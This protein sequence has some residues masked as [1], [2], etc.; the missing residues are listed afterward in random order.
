MQRFGHLRMGLTA[1]YS[2]TV[3]KSINILMETLSRSIASDVLRHNA[4]EWSHGYQDASF[5]KLR[6]FLWHEQ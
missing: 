6:G 5:E 4:V 3:E 2:D 1:T